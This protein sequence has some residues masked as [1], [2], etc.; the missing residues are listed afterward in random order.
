[1]STSLGLFYVKRWGNCVHYTFRFI[2]GVEFA[3]CCT[4]SGISIKYERSLNRSLWPIDE[5]K[6]DTNTLDQSWPD[7]D[8]NER[9]L[10]HRQNYTL[11]TTYSLIS[12]PR[13]FLFI[14]VGYSHLYSQYIQSL[15]NHLNK[16][17]Q[18]TSN[19][20]IMVWR[21]SCKLARTGKFVQCHL[22]LMTFWQMGL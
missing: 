15:T 21:F 9:V 18:G 3:H 14:K 5:I 13:H 10:H 12:Y 8:Y 16:K 1:M 19:F 17:D 11:I 20:F 22:L 7:S 2:C 6:T 4:T